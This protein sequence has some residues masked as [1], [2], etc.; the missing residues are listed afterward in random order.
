MTIL[1]DKSRDSSEDLTVCNMMDMGTAPSLR[2]VLMFCIR[3]LWDT[4][5]I[6]LV[7]FILVCS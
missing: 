5:S 4:E 3:I 6:I 1:I 7:E 2:L